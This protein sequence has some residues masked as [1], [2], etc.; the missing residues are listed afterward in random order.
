[1]LMRRNDKNLFILGWFDFI[2]LE[3]KFCILDFENLIIFEDIRGEGV[4]III[5]YVVFF[6]GMGVVL[7]FL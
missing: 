1:M 2:D 4:F 5:M 7:D 6:L 3:F